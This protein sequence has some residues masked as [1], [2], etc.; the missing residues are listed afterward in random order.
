MLER[1]SGIARIIVG[2]LGWSKGIEIPSD[3]VFTVALRYAFLRSSF[4]HLS[5]PVT[6]SDLWPD[7]SKLPMP[8]SILSDVFLYCLMLFLLSA[9]PSAPL[10]I[11]L[12]LQSSSCTSPHFSTPLT[13]VLFIH[14][15]LKGV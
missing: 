12:N 2:K 1:L 6:S 11:S 10:L 8:F 4:L 13:S 15:G 9:Y 7:P 3:M 14:A 5:C